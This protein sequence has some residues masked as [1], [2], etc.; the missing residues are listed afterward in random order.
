M[1]YRV[2][3]F[4]SAENDLREIRSYFEEV[5]QTD[6]DRLIDKFYEALIPLVDSPY[7]YA[8][9]KDPVLGARGFHSVAVDNYLVFFKVVGDTVQIHRFIYGRRRFSSL[10]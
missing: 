5:L 1:K 8:S 3:I 2:E 4:P 10:L 6:A 9:V 7:M